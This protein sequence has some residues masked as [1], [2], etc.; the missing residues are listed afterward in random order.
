MPVSLHAKQRA[1]H[2]LHL[3]IA[4]LVPPV[5][6]HSDTPKLSSLATLRLV[7]YV[8]PL[9]ASHHFQSCTVLAIDSTADGS[10]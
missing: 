10:V 8:S 7:D 1:M 6:R 3:E 2:Q 5:R 9:R 4:E